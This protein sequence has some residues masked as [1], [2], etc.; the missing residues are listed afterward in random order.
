[1]SS[2]GNLTLENLMLNG[3]DNGGGISST[4]NVT[5]TL[6]SGAVIRNCRS[7]TDNHGGGINFKHNLSTINIKPGALISNNTTPGDWSFGGGIY[8]EG[9]IEMD[10]G[11][12]T[13]NIGAN[14]GGVYCKGTF[15]MRGGTISENV[16]DPG[17]SPSPQ[18]HKNGGGVYNEGIFTMI[19]G[20]ISNNTSG[21][22]GGG[23]MN[24]A[25]FKMTG[26]TISNNT[27]G[28][29]ASG[30]NNMNGVNPIFIMEGGT[31]S[32]N[33]SNGDSYHASAVFNSIT[34]TFIMRSG[35]IYGNTDLLGTRGIGVWNL[36]NFTMEGGEISN[37][38]LGIRNTRHFTMSGGKISNNRRQ[39]VESQQPDA[40]FI[41]EDGEIINNNASGVRNYY[42]LFTMNGGKISGNNGFGNPKAEGGGVY[43]AYGGTVTINGGEISYNTALDGGGIYSDGTSGGDIHFSPIVISTVTI[44]GGVIVHN[45][46]TRN[47]GGLFTEEHATVTVHNGGTNNVIFQNNTA[48]TKTPWLTTNNKWGAVNTVYQTQCGTFVPSTANISALPGETL[49]G[50][51][52]TYDNLYNNYDI[53]LEI[54]TLT[55][56]ANFG[57]M[58]DTET[59][60]YISGSMGTVLPGMFTR[61]GYNFVEWNTKPSGTGTAYNPNSSVTVND[62]TTLYA[63]WTLLPGFYE[64]ELWNCPPNVG[65]GGNVYERTIAVEYGEPMPSGVPPSVIKPAQYGSFPGVFLGYGT[66]DPYSNNYGGTWKIYYNGEMESVRNWD[67][68]KDTALYGIWN[69]T[70]FDLVMYHANGGTFDDDLSPFYQGDLYYVMHTN[71]NTYILPPTAVTRNGYL[72]TGWSFN[73]SGGAGSEVTELTPYDNTKPKVVYAQWAPKI[74]V[75]GTVFPFVYQEGENGFNALFP[76]TVSLKPIPNNLLSPTVYEDLLAETPLFSEN[77]I[78]YDGTLFVEGTPKSPGALGEFNNFGLPINFMDALGGGI[79]HGA[80]ASPTLLNLEKPDNNEGATVGVFTLEV[81][82]GDYILEIKRDGYMVRWAKITI[83]AQEPTVHLGHRELIPGDVKTMLRIDSDNAQQLLSMIEQGLHHTHTDYEPHLDLN[84][85]GYID[86]HD[87]YLLQKYIGFRFYHY[88]ETM[89]WLNE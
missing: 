40:T 88:E 47:G 6:N 76:I 69:N 2:T 50:A 70:A 83:D 26:G 13:G 36:N 17:P 10:G 72:L 61:H 20:N 78:Y 53:N 51:S 42:G 14:G 18:P 65:G 3:N 37:N 4:A 38:Y 48:A 84:A 30:V 89:D 68:P 41:M 7:L 55:Y 58:S 63:Q 71:T 64:V 81:I 22:A 21:Y 54:K 29:G 45:T 62:N 23:V 59:Y 57:I 33:L 12:I 85:D 73:A 39:G 44:N 19:S 75:T 87:Y 74:T 15:V 79:V 52:A 5:L 8:S 80:S 16:A 32:R 9:M 77:A 46:A 82:P 67:I 35:T 31:I 24:T 1:M 11:T 49:L 60:Y 34:S 56:H 25:E 28:S 86:I 27:S 66:L 43:N